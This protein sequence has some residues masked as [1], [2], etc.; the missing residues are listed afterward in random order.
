M[1]RLAGYDWPGNV[2]ELSNVL[3]RA[4][5][6]AEGT[7]ITAD[8]L[9]DTVAGSVPAIGAAAPVAPYDLE[10]VERAHVADVLTRMKG[11]KLQAAKAL[12]ISRRALYRLIDKYGLAPGDNPVTTPVEPG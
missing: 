4:Q 11:N 6:L 10:V 5:I 1:T 3:E 8:D 2:R 12:G 9:P 7:V